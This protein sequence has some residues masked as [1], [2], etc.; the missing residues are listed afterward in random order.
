METSP[1][2]S[3][4]TVIVAGWTGAEHRTHTLWFM[5]QRFSVC[6]LSF[7]TTTRQACHTSFLLSV[8]VHDYLSISCAVLFFD[9]CALLDLCTPAPQANIDNPV[10]R[11]SLTHNQTCPFPYCFTGCV[12][13]RGIGRREGT[14]KSPITNNI[15]FISGFPLFSLWHSILSFTHTSTYTNTHTDTHIFLLVLSF[16]FLSRRAEGKRAQQNFMSSISFAV[17][18]ALIKHKASL[19]YCAL[20]LCHSHSAL[21]AFPS[22][23]LTNNTW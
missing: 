19:S 16:V 1:R 10:S 13:V 14:N 23:Y 22:K 11:G 2:V 9:K 7:V 8:P 4:R 20:Y 6:L 18:S 12:F 15:A 5:A 21:S 17:E 3:T